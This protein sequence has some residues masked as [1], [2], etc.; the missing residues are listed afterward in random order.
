MR[1]DSACDTS[2]PLRYCLVYDPHPSTFS[3]FQKIEVKKP[4]HLED[5]ILASYY[6]NEVMI[7]FNYGPLCQLASIDLKIR[8]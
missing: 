5:A 8:V 4:L 7:R 6:H 1:A 2:R 3:Q